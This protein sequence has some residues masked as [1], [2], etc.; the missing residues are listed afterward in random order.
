[1][2]YW[3]A[4]GEP[5]IASAREVVLGIKKPQ[6]IRLEFADFDV[7]YTKDLLSFSRY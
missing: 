7:L 1:E 3:P 6:A 5:F 2:D 4:V